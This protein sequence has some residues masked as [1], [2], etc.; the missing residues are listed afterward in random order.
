MSQELER[1]KLLSLFHYLFGAVVALFACIP[2]IHLII[3]LVMILSP[4]I[5]CSTADCSDMPPQYLGWLFAIIGGTFVL[6]GWAYAVLLII[7][8]R[9]IAQHRRYKFCF[10]I[11]VLSCTCVPLGTVLGVFTLMQL[12]QPA[13]KEHFSSYGT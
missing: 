1:L 4:Q 10:A 8:G 11:A 13:V 12:T 7:A 5:F 3:G 2:I 9:N 6:L